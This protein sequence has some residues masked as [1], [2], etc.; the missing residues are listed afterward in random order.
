MEDRKA[1]LGCD[2]EGSCTIQVWH[3]KGCSVGLALGHGDG[4]SLCSCSVEKITVF[5]LRL[6]CF[7]KF[8]DSFSQ[9][10]VFRLLVCF[11]SFKN[12][13]LCMK[14]KVSNNNKIR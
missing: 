13:C 7:V 3:V 12:N 11:A 9:V 6:F 4:P 2:A 8:L 5:L 10:F 14:H 1:A